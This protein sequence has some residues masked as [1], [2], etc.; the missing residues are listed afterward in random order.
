MYLFVTLLFLVLTALVFQQPGR[1]LLIA[2]KLTIRSAT[3]HSYEDAWIFQA[4][5]RTAL[6]GLREWF[7]GLELRR[8]MLRTEF[9]WRWQK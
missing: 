8:E 3:N 6:A 1:D 9:C 4:C 7:G 5:E 2:C